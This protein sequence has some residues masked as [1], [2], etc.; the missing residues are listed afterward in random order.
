MVAW[1]EGARPDPKPC[2]PQ[3]RSRFEITQRDGRA[4]LGRLH[5]DHGVLETPALLPV[6][7]P[8]IR[9]IEPREMWDRYGI[10]A[11]ITNSYI[12]WKHEDLKEQA[13]AN[14]V[15]EL[16]NFPGVIMTDSGTFQ[17]YIYGDVEVG[18]DEIVSFQRS[19]G[20]DIATMLDVFS[21]PDMTM[22]EVEH[23]VRETEKRAAQS[24]VATA[25]TMLNGPIQGGVFRELRTL[26]A[27]LMGPHGFSVHP[28]GGIVPVMEQQRYKEYAK[29]MLS[30]IPYL[31]PER[32]VHMFGCG[33]PML[34]PMSI[35]LGADL[36]DS[37]AYAIFARDGRLLT[38]W[39]TERIDEL[40]DWPMLMPCVAT[41]SPEDV[42]KMETLAREQLLA[43]FN[44]EVTLSELAR[45]KQA[46][47]EGKIWQ[48]AEQRSHLHPA[49]R[50]A[51]LWLSTPPKLGPDISNELLFTEREA[52]MDTDKDRG[53]WED[54]W[55]WLVW[56]QH[57]PRTG[58]VMWGGDDTF[59]RP[60]IQQARRL[61]HTRWVAPPQTRSVLVFHGIKGPFRSR[62]N[63]RFIWLQHH[64][65][66]VQVLMLTPIGLVP[67]SLEDSNP[68]A[69]L[70]APS[71]VLNHRPEGPWFERELA[72]LGLGDLPY[73][74]VNAQGDGVRLRMETA[75]ASLKHKGESEVMNDLEKD[76]ASKADNELN[77]RQAQDK[78][79]VMLNV[80]ATV[81]AS[82]THG[83]S[84]LINRQGRVRNVMDAQ[85]DHIL[86]P[87]LYDGG[88]S[89]T[90]AGA[91]LIAKARSSP[92][93][94]RMEGCEWRGTAGFGPAAVIVEGDAEPFVRK[95][96]NVFHGF[97]SAC[98]GWL[99]PG[100]AC[101][102]YNQAGEL[103]GH[104]ISQCTSDEM[105]G[106]Q[107]GV[108]VKTRGGFPSEEEV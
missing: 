104:G 79:I 31:P 102:I 66:D 54:A 87:R 92:L 78:M 2:R 8:N 9:T 50:E 91:S 1:K 28:I 20:V 51:F 29:I 69:H 38:P 37:A 3:D 13:Q 74:T 24:V 45:C 49:L 30:T 40:V 46:V 58:G 43:K 34:F 21:R 108:A 6:V 14:G 88:I 5:T 77:M 65:P 94:T 82:S 11:L 52:A 60:H 63:D 85:G 56:S 44:L 95:G 41:V 107:K 62:L 48:L 76:M 86:S 97:I 12:I 96:R 33:H 36:F 83:M 68:F 105:A 98:D 59:V 42:R 23:A 103:L 53:M 106:F 16:L 18:I 93:P 35:A 101:L 61:L 7:N 70:D 27:Q 25:D 10:G 55:D 15:H 57:T 19:I 39:G 89:L 73:A 32:P 80:D 100:E 84:F 64:C 90:N 67:I 71:W 72:R 75:L 4:R 99:A 81:A 22:D 47:R 17:S 26:S